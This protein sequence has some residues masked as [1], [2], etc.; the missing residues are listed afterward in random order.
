MVRETL[1]KFT[2]TNPVLHEYQKP[3]KIEGFKYGADERPREIAPRVK[4]ESRILHNKWGFNLCH[5]RVGLMFSY[6][7]QVGLRF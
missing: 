4:K 6:S 2:A 7:A 1:T 5:G 3:F